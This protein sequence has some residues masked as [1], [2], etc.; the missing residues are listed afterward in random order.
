MLTRVD[1]EM[2]DV[3]ESVNG[4]PDVIMAVA[5]GL[6]TVNVRPAMG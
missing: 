5:I 4:D 1:E 6:R 3:Q 2:V